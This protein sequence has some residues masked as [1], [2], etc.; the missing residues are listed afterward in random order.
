MR[1]KVYQRKLY[2]LVHYILFTCN[3]PTQ[4]H[5]ITQDQHTHTPILR[6]LSVSLP[7]THFVP[8]LRTIRSCG[9]GGRTGRKILQARNHFLSLTSSVDMFSPVVELQYL[10]FA[11]SSQPQYVPHASCSKDITKGHIPS[12]YFHKH[13]TPSTH[14]CSSGK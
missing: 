3:R 5:H 12:S 10:Y 14:L 6:L 2:L 4:L 13:K 8:L 9:R 11:D 7:I 1:P